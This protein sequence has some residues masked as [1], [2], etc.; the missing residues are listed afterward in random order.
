MPPYPFIFS[1]FSPF[2]TQLLQSTKKTLFRNKIAILITLIPQHHH[3]Q[4]Y[5]S[6]SPAQHRSWRLQSSNPINLNPTAQAPPPTESVTMHLS[7]IA[8][9]ATASWNSLLMLTSSTSVT[10]ACTSDANTV[11][12]DKGASEI[13]A[14]RGCGPLACYTR[15]LPSNME[16][17][18]FGGLP[19]KR[20]W[21]VRC[22]RYCYPMG[23]PPCRLVFDGKGAWQSASEGERAHGAGMV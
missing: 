7:I 3:N 22:F 8:A 14:W 6:K 1:F 16:G 18:Y 17:V 12:C 11:L 19:T 20:A 5:T 10:T 2:S 4:N 9:C 13:F 21:R 15:G 23:D